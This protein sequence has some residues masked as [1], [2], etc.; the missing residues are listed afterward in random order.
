MATI[1]QTMERHG[2]LERHG[3]RGTGTGN[4]QW[5]R[6]CNQQL[7]KRWSAMVNGN[8]TGPWSPLNSVQRNKDSWLTLFKYR[9]LIL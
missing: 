9:K 7:T 8:G 5:Q 4:G 6:N 1:N 2:G 3:Q